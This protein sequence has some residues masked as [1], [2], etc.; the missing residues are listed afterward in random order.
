MSYHDLYSGKKSKMKYIRTPDDIW[1][2]LSAEFNFT[3]DACASD[4]NHLVDK[5][6][7]AETDALKQEWDNEIIYCHPMFDRHIPKFIKKAIDS[8]SLCVFLLP[9]STHT[10]YFKKYL[11]SDE[12]HSPKPDIQLR[13]LTKPIGEVRKGFV[14][15]TEDNQIPKMG[16]IRQLMIVVIDRRGNKND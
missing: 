4:K 10:I 9:A 3:V 8:N 15:K 11:W 6:W 2:S 14:F 7:T 5:Y 13:F 16:Y 12:T 1:E